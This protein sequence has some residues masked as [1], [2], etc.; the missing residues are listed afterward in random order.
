VRES[1][2]GPIG[3]TLDLVRQG[4]QHIAQ[5]RQDQIQRLPQPQRVGV[6]FNIGAGCAQVHYPAP[7]LAPS[8]ESP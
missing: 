2:T 4:A 6:V 5:R 8:G 7:D 3:P 1:H